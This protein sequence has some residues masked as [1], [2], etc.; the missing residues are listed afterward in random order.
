M[1]ASYGRSI[2]G[3]T[4]MDYLG[5]SAVEQRVYDNKVQDE[6]VAALMIKGCKYNSLREWL[7]NQQLAPGTECA[8][9]KTSSGAVK[10]ID[11]GNWGKETGDGKRRGHNNPRK[12]EASEE[13]II[14]SHVHDNN[15]DDDDETETMKHVMATIGSTG[16]EHRNAYEPIQ[17]KEE[18]DDE[19]IGEV[20]GSI[21]T[22]IDR[23]PNIPEQDRYKII[24]HT[25]S[26]YDDIRDLKDR[27]HGLSISDRLELECEYFTGGGMTHGPGC[28]FH[29]Q[30]NPHEEREHIRRMTFEPSPSSDFLVSLKVLLHRLALLRPEEEYDT[31]KM[32]KD[33]NTAGIACVTDLYN[34]MTKNGPADDY[35]DI[36]DYDGIANKYKEHDIPRLNDI[37]VIYLRGMA[38]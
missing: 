19:S 11:N 12:Q 37:T 4:I 1:E 3:I 8:Y 33:L 24:D 31:T 9:P 2:D 30:F 17:N 29:P 6:L 38:Q 13:D 26:I 18:F 28:D 34:G 10:L 7:K 35:G 32:E 25:D 20:V 27:D 21:T 36:A 22:T 14:G 5:L 15:E 23:L 16:I